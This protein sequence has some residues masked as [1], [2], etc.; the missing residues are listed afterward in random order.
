MSEDN[1]IPLFKDVPI[2]PN[3]PFPWQ[4]YV[5]NVR[6]VQEGFHTL[7]AHY[8]CVA[9]DTLADIFCEVMEGIFK[10]KEKEEE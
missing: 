3:K 8:K 9:F 10:D 1:V 7:D 6:R 5:D 2:T 4:D